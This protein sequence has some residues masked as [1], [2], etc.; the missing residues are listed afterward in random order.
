MPEA[1]VQQVADHIDYIR[2]RIGVDGIGLGSDFDG[3]PTLPVGLEDVSKYPNLVVE[4]L[5]RGYRDE[6]VKKIIGLNV[7]RVLREAER[8]AADLR[9]TEAPSAARIEELDAP[10]EAETE[11][12]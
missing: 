7:L 3:S 9:R 4:L 12:E 2:D 11:T 6:D 1:T 10:A 5:K 8:V